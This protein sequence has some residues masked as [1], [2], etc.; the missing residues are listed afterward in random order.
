MR[1]GKGWIRVDP[2]STS[3]GHLGTLCAPE[4][5]WVCPAFPPGAQ[6]LLRAVTWHFHYTA[7]NCYTFSNIGVSISSVLAVRSK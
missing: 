4:L 3:S 7:I 5:P 2:G 6:S 1:Y